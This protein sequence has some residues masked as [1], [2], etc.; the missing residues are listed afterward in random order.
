MEQTG[1]TSDPR[2]IGV[3][4]TFVAAVS[5]T[6][7]NLLPLL[8]IYV[9]IAVPMF[10]LLMYACPTMFGTMMSA[11]S[12]TASP[13]F[14]F[15]AH[16]WIAFAGI[17]LI[18]LGFGAWTY[19]AAFRMADAVLAGEPRP[20]VRGAFG[21][22][23]ERVPAFVGACIC[24]FLVTLVGFLFCVLPGIFIA[25]A[26]NLAPVRSVVRD[27][28]PIDAIRESYALVKG[29]WWRVF[30]FFL[31]VALCIQAIYLPMVLPLQFAMMGQGGIPAWSMPISFVISILSTL[32]GI[33]QMVCVTAMNRQLELLGPVESVPAPIHEDVPADEPEHP[34]ED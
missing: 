16:E 9:I 19:A 24:M 8:G 10:L 11:R 22:S 30:G 4:P 18:G 17:M 26:A 27:S 15:P 5:A 13:G 34:G 14:D 3:L 1:G 25:V 33:F 23:L 12:T 28:G 2:S 20:S 7:K 31:L 32:L 6:R 21:A 29:R